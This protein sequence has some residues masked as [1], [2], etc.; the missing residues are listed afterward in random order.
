MILYLHKGYKNNSVDAENHSCGNVQNHIGGDV[1]NHSRLS[2]SHALLKRALEIHESIPDAAELIKSIR[3]EGEG[4]PYI[5]G[6]DYFSISHSGD[7]WVALFSECECGFD[8]QVERK[9]DYLKIAERWFSPD[10]TEK[11]KTARDFFELWTRREAYAKVLG[12]SVFRP[13]GQNS[14]TRNEVNSVT[15]SKPDSTPEPDFESQRPRVQITSFMLDELTGND[16]DSF[17]YA[18]LAL[19]CGQQFA[20][21]ERIIDVT[22]AVEVV[23]I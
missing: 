22:E 2:E 19:R 11:I 8:V 4:K 20:E 15:E 10:E 5:D 6:T 7:Y 9:C 17:I 21:L 14:G 13:D 1:Q 3:Y 23:Y 18:A 16:A 12:T